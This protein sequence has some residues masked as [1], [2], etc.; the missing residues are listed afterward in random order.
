MILSSTN[1]FATL[2]GIIQQSNAYISIS[3]SLCG[4]VLDAVL[5][6]RKIVQTS[7][8]AEANERLSRG[9]EVYIGVLAAGGYEFTIAVVTVLALGAT[10]VPMCEYTTPR[11]Y[12]L[13][14]IDPSSPR[15][16]L[17][18]I[19]YYTAKS[20]QLAILSSSTTT[21]IAQSAAKSCGLVKQ[22]YYLIYRRSLASQH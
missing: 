6:L 5:L 12:L 16:S 14:K 21:E 19:V 8:P 1:C 20:Q 22:A 11:V 7:L 18:E 2:D 10:V 13:Y 9:D 17:D 3:P 4:E 15:C